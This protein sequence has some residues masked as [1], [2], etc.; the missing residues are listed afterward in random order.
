MLGYLQKRPLRECGSAMVVDDT[1]LQA[2]PWL[3]RAEHMQFPYGSM[4]LPIA[5]GRVG[6]FSDRKGMAQNI[7]VLAERF[8]QNYVDSSYS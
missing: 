3:A 4:A 6:A 5:R 7:G 2:N 1:F 8:F